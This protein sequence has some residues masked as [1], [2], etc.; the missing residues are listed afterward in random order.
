MIFYTMIVQRGFSNFGRIDPLCQSNGATLLRSDTKFIY[1]HRAL[2]IQKF[3]H[4]NAFNHNGSKR[5]L[6]LDIVVRNGM[7]RPGTLVQSDRKKS[8]SACLRR[9]TNIHRKKVL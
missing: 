3:K 4:G 6:G 2:T 9:L 1:F 8:T 7:I 5:H